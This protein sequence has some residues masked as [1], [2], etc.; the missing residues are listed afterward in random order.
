MF[1]YSFFGGGGGGYFH[2]GIFVQLVSVLFQLLIFV[3]FFISVNTNVFCFVLYSLV[4]ACIIG[5]VFS[6]LDNFFCKKMV[7]QAVLF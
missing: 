2:C 4:N 7:L 5:G 1:R 3:Y 6:L